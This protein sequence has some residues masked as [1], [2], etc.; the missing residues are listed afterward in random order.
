[1]ISFTRHR[2]KAY[3]FSAV[4]LLAGLISLA[5]SGMNLG[6]DFT[7]GTVF[8]LNLGELFTVEQVQ[9]V[10]RPFNLQ[11][12]S[13]QVVQGQGAQGEIVA[14]GVVVKSPHLDEGRRQEVLDAFQR[15]WPGMAAGDLR[16][17][18]VGAVIGGELTRQA[19]LSLVVA[20]A[21]MIAY[22][23]IRFEFK[24]ALA[25]IAALLHDIL[26]VLGIFS[27]FRLEI[28]VPFA[29]AILTIFGYSVNDTIVVIDRIRE[30]I[31]NRRKDDYPAIVDLSIRQS[32][33]RCMNTSLT[34]L[35]VLIGLFIGFN[36]FIGGLD[37]IFFVVALIIGVVV[38]TYSSIFIASPLWLEL[39]ELEFHRAR[40]R[41]ELVK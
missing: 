25:T 26:I 27:I 17:E 33:V 24:F 8:H 16:V 22:I 3:L 6:I 29:A 40:R 10:L 41:R 13:I 14:E 37:L 35:I 38:G 12:S 2:R 34:T 36:Y 31:K 39:K 21:A 9:E 1:M 30:N 20:I 15:R 11:G 19:L 28:N 5:V 18:S 4:L 23:T 32:L 7:G